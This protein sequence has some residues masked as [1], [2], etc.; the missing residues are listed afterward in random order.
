MAPG[1]MLL[2][3]RNL[4]VLEGSMITAGYGNKQVKSFGSLSSGGSVYLIFDKLDLID[5][6]ISSDG[7]TSFD[8]K[9]GPGGG[10]RILLYDIC[11]FSQ[12][13][14]KKKYKYN[15]KSSQITVKAGSRILDNNIKELKNLIRAENGSNIIFTINFSNCLYSLSA[16]LQ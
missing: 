4:Q 15:Y 8:Y 9:T 12:N 1:A 16:R 7:Q 10:G 5:S 3:T 6:S 14:D 13:I 2:V 11:W